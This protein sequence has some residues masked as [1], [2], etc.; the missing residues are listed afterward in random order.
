MGGGGFSTH[1]PDPALDDFVLGLA[2]GRREPRICLL[3]TAGGDAQE[4]IVRFQ[5]AFDDRACVAS[6]LSLFRLGRRPVSLREHLLGQDIIYVG[7]GSMLN[8]LAIW[9][10][11]ELDVVMREAWEAGVVL[12]G[13]S[14]GSMCWFEGGITTS[15]GR[16]APAAGLGF[17][18][19]SNSVH[20]GSEPNR[21][22]AFLAAVRE[23]ALPDGWGIDDGVGLLFEGTELTDVVSARPR[24]GAVRVAREKDEPGVSETPVAHRRL[25]DGPRPGLTPPTELAELRRMRDAR[26]TANRL[27]HRR[28]GMRD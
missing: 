19:G 22:P 6:H 14:A 21:R 15:T 4:Q 5:A 20:Y 24:A 26:P 13:L 17:L 3:P 25:P 8:M 2:Q 18:R 11:H 27:G 1:P 7:G 28:A 23:G 10:A 12:C 9:R 16:P